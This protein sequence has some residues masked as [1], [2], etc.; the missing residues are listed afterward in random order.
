M[1]GFKGEDQFSET[2]QITGDS[3]QKLELLTYGRLSRNQKR[4]WILAVAAQ[5]E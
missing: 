2:S 1:H 5:L 4:L 3:R